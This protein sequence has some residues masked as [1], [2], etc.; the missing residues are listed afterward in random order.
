MMR[1]RVIINAKLTTARFSNSI[2]QSVRDDALLVMVIFVPLTVAHDQTKCQPEVGS[3]RRNAV[4]SHSPIFTK[5][6]VDN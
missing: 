3:S 6:A 2:K 1:Q 4:F 5:N